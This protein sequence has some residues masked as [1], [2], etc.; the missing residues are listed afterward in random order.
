MKKFV[1]ATMVCMLILGLTASTAMASGGCR[2]WIRV[3]RGQTLSGIAA[4]WGTSVRALVNANHIKNPNR[5]YTGQSLCIPKKGAKP[6]KKCNFYYKVKRGDWVYSIA[7]RYHVRPNCVIRWNGLHHPNRVYP[8]QKIY[9][10]CQC[11]Y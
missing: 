5:I 8:G 4:A 6:A 9:I 2:K 10:P 7:R 3:K 11:R 1:L